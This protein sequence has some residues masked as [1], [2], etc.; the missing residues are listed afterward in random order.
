MSYIRAGEKKLFSKSQN[1][2]LYVFLSG[3]DEEQ[4]IEDYGDLK[5]PEDFC[6]IMF[7]ILDQGG[8]EVTKEMVNKARDRLGLEPVDEVGGEYGKTEEFKEKVTS[9]E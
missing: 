3:T 4:Y 8:V 7:R 9:N 6:E 2:G 1:Q 5:N